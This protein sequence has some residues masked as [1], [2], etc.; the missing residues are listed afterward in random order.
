[1]KKIER[2]DRSNIEGL[3]DDAAKVL[4]KFAAERDVTVGN[5]GG[6]KFSD[7]IFTTR[8][9]FEVADAG[10]VNWN[11]YAKN[12]GLKPEFFG[13][14]FVERG[15]TYRIVGFAPGRKYSVEVVRTRDDET[16]FVTPWTVNR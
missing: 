11:R 7:G 15:E 3:A 16:F 4:K 12:H 8:I 14:E 5:A 1:M 10:R 13:Q 2:F 9:R 6:G